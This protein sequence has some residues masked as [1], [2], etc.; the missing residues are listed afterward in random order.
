MQRNSTGIILLAAGSSSRMGCPKQLLKINNQTLI[1]R[2]IDTALAAEQFKPLLIVLGAN[3]ELIR[4]EIPTSEDIII[5]ENPGWQEGMGSSV[6]YGIEQANFQGLDGA[7][8][9]L[10]DQPL[11]TAS[12]LLALYQKHQE[13]GLPVVASRYSGFNAVPVYFHHSLFPFLLRSKGDQGAR[14]IIN[15]YPGVVA[16]DFPDG[17]LDVD[18]PERFEEVK[19]L[20]ERDD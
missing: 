4:K 15:Q 1:R 7:V 18:T 6:R 12:H 10:C 13:T 16:I 20:I 8:V 17:A 5:V 14:K 9:M 2:A 3:A 19:S 11:L